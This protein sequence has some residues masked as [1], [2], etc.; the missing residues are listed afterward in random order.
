MAEYN[1]ESGSRPRSFQIWIIPNGKGGEPAW[2]AKPFPE[3]RPLQE[4]GW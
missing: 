3:I 4:A 1:L 2:G